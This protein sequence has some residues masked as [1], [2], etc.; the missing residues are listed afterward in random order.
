M[1]LCAHPCTA[2]RL[3]ILTAWG[4]L[5]GALLILIGSSLS[6]GVTNTLSA[7]TI[8]WLVGS[9]VFLV[10][11]MALMTIALVRVHRLSSCR[12]QA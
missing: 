11:M 9:W 6:V 2:A 4:E 7:G 3:L 1:R 10:S 8:L 12:G 5:V